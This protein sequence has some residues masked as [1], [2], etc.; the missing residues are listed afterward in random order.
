M[1]SYILQ[2]VTGISPVVVLQ[3]VVSSVTVGSVNLSEVVILLLVTV[4]TEGVLI[5]ACN[6]V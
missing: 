3:G 4:D 5:L 1:S 6:I 2:S